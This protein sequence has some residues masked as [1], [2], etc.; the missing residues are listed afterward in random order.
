MAFLYTHHLMSNTPPSSELHQQ[1][2]FAALSSHWE[3]ALQLNQQI[4]EADPKN[5]DAF[6]RLGRAYFEL[7]DLSQAQHCFETSMKID[8][9]NQIAAKFLKRIETFSKTGAKIENYQRQAA[10]V[11]GDS[12][13]EEPGKTTLVNL[14][15][16]AEPYK[17][18][19]L[20]PGGEVKLI[21]KN[22]GISVMDHNGKYLGVLP[23]DISHRLIRL[24]HGGNKYQAFI[25]AIKT[26]SV[27]ILIREIFRSSRFKNQPSFLDNFHVNVTYSSD[28][29]VLVDGGDET[30]YES[31][32]EET[33]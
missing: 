14:L 6:N 23:D 9:Y 27:S 1:A 28:H 11:N 16:T 5:I 24:I 15:K 7:G 20:S 22:R 2:I 3:E 4:I 29:I 31:E 8:P 26:N 21:I 17:L 13:I 30:S 33:V 18:S 32:E 25:K 12:F 19:L 10:P